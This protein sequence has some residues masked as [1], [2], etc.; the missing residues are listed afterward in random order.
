MK[1][2]HQSKEIYTMTF[3][4]ICF[5]ITDKCNLNC[6]YC[7][8]FSS[9]NQIIDIDKFRI[10]VRKLVRLGCKTINITGGEPLLN[11]NWREFVNIC[12]EYGLKIILSTTGINLDLDDQYLND[13][14][15]LTLP[16][17]GY[18]SKINSMTRG[19]KHY[20]FVVDLI[21]KY[22][23][24]N[25]PFKLKIN[26]VVTKYNY[27]SLENMGN[28]I[29]NSNIIWKLF[30]YRK[31]GIHNIMD[32]DLLVD[33]IDIQ[34]KLVE[35]LDLKLHCWIMEEDIL[36]D[37]ANPNEYLSV[38]CDGIILLSD[39]KEDIII[40]DLVSMDE[41]TIYSKFRIIKPI[42]KPYKSLIGD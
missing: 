26:T 20:Q 42:A 27:D 34:K 18:N 16:L 13:L 10:C 1:N 8:R 11:P 38:N 6:P 30:Q 3:E 2:Y 7:F 33:N 24:G 32:K 17:D 40:G 35:L 14:Y 22:I 29:D 39:D 4:Y 12:K 15:V 23:S 41:D 21:N 31:K 25:Y 5:S 28:L 37:L 36:N 9:E 19:D